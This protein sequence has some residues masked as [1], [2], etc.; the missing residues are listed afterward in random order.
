MEDIPG[1]PQGERRHLRDWIDPLRLYDPRMPAGRLVFLWGLAIFP[2]VVIF[3]LLTVIL[4]VVETVSPNVNPDYIGIIVWPFM[5]AWVAATVAI[6]RR[7]LLQL[8]RSQKW[9]WVAILPI[10]NLPLFLYLLVKP[11]PVASHRVA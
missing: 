7:R 6:T 5:L 8:E 4:I 2:P 9:V 11:G 1:S 10:V 3:V